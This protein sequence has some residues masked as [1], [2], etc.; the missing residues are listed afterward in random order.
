MLSHSI[1]LLCKIFIKVSV[2]IGI[3]TLRSCF[4]EVDLFS[5]K[6]TFQVY[7]LKP[8]N[9]GVFGVREMTNVANSLSNADP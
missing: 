4:P 1:L 3:S 2:N 6:E 7:S 9:S 8:V 5:L